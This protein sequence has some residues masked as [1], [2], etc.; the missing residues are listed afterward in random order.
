[1]KIATTA[2]LVLTALAAPA[3]AADPAP[4]ADWPQHLGPN[5][6]GVSA[7]V[8][9]IDAIPAGGPKEVWRIKGG[10]GM[11]GVAVA[12]G[13][14]V[15]L[16][17]RNDRQK[18]VAV[19]ALTGAARWE[20]ELAR[21]YK[22]QMGDGPRAT[23]TIAGDRVFAFTGEGILVAVSLA[24]GKKLWSHDVPAELKGEPNEYG[25]ASSPL[26]AG[27]QVIVSANAPS[28]AVAAYD[29]ETGKLAWTAG[30]EPAG[31]AS[32]ALLTVGGK[33]QVVVPTGKSVLGIAPGDGKVLWRHPWETNYNC[34]TATPVAVDGRVLVSAGE[35]HGSALLAVDGAA[36]KPVW[37]SLG[38]R[39]VLRSEWQTP[40]LVNGHLYGFDNVGGAG[41]VSHLTCLDA[42]TGARAWQQARYGKGNLIAADGKLFIVT[43]DGELVIAR[44]LPK[45]Y[46]ELGRAKVVGRTRQAPS[47]ASGLLYLRD[48]EDVVCVD[49]RKR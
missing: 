15:T 35:N 48:D 32:A 46:A 3:R 25:M 44:A 20:T 40:V 18:L 23:P 39:S 38:P 1:M 7:E 24:D 2:L 17:H 42:A 9:L 49:V 12:R 8:G 33:P 28:G 16:A 4:A 30:D 47:L 5:R 21:P 34:N 19:D 45:G 13:L 10:V 31:Y 26:V 14:A 27:G 22:N 36:A 6:N 29:A 37:E 41:P 11:S 43:F